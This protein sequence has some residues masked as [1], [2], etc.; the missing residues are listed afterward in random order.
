VIADFGLSKTIKTISQ[1]STTT[2]FRG[3]TLHWQAPELFDNPATFTPESDVYSYGMIVWEV[4]SGAFPVLIT[5]DD[6]S[7]PTL[8]STPW[9]GMTLLEIMRAVTSGRQLELSEAVITAG[10]TN[11]LHADYFRTIMTLCFSNQPKDRPRFDKVI[12]YIDKFNAG[13][14]VSALR[15]LDLQQRPARR[16]EQASVVS[17][18]VGV[19]ECDSNYNSDDASGH[20]S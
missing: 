20:V 5:V 17:K 6:S 1:R 2:T 4:L 18:V 19:K 15:R 3:A 7:T 11:V 8:S 16:D 14:H 12:E 13:T 9:S 10:D